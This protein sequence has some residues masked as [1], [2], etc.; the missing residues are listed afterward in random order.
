MKNF[1]ATASITINV[2]ADAAWRAL[3]DP[4]MIK[5]YL[6]GTEAISDWQEGSSLTYRGEWEGK[7]YEDKGTIVEVV[8]Q[9]RLTTT[10]WSSLSGKV[11][12]PENYSTVVY[13]LDETDGRTT[14]TITQDN[15]PT[16]ESADHSQNNWQNVLRTMKK[17]LE[18]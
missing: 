10:Y 5:Q 3:T 14:L 13:E 6:F 4:A 15:N 11:D 12:T 1:I 9:K 17:L 16:Q 18:Q 7:S 8:P 2:G